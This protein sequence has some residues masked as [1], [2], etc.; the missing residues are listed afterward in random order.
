MKPSTILTLLLLLAGIAALSA[1]GAGGAPP[2]SNQGNSPP[3]PIVVS[4]SPKA[5]SIQLTTQRQFTANASS[6]TVSWSI[7]TGGSA[8][9]VIDSNG[10]YSAPSIMPGSTVLTIRATSTSDPGV[11]DDATVTLTAAPVYGA[12]PVRFDVKSRGGWQANVAPVTCGIPLLPGLHNNANTL[13][14]QA[15]PGGA[16]VPAQ[17]RVTSRWPSGHIRWVMVDFLADLSGTGGIGQ[18]QLNNGG[19]GNATGTN[20]TVNNGANDIVVN[21]GLVEFTVSKNSFNLLSSVR[22]QRDGSG[23]LDECLTTAN[24]EGLVVTEGANDYLTDTI[25]PTRV[26]VEESGPMRVTIV[27]EGVHRSALSVNKLDYTVRITAYNDLPFIG[28]TYSFKNKTGDGVAAA[29]PAAAAAQLAQY[30]VVDS[31]KLDL[32]LDFQ[33]ASPSARVGGNPI[34]YSA[35]GMTTGQYLEL[36]QYYSGAHDATDP[37]NPQP[38]GYNST[39]GD[40]SSDPLTNTWP[41]DSDTSIEYD[42]D[43]SGT[44]STDSTHAPGWVQMAGGNLS[45]TAA[46]AEFWQQYPKQLRAQAD[47]RLRVG[48]WPDAAAPLEVFAGVMKTHRMLLSFDATG[49][50]NTPAAEARYNI[51]NDPPRAVCRPEHYAAT[52]VFGRIAWTDETLTNTS[53][54]R[55]QSQAF[56]AAYMD[57]VVDHMGDILFD[58]TDGNGTATGHEYGMWNFGDSKHSSPVDGWENNAW[59]ISSAAFQWFAMSG[60]LELLNLAETTLRHFRDVD[61]L[62]ADIGTRFDYTEAGNPAVSGGKASQL[63]KTRYFANNKQHDMGNYHFGEN[64]LD[65]FNGAFLAEHWLL[66]GDATSLDV[67]KEIYIYLR[68]TWKRFFDSANG[69]QDDTMTAPTTWLSNGLMIAMAYERANGINDTS[70]NVMAQL[71]LQVV[72]T[73]QATPTTNDPSGNGFADNTGFFRAWELGHMAEALEWARNTLDDVTVDQTILNFMN[74][75]LGTNANVYL[76]NLPTPQF[77]EFSETTGGTTDYGG[78]NLMI[79]AGYIGAFRESNNAN[80]QTAADNLV[81]M[82]TPNIDDATIGDDAIRHSSFAQFFRAGPMLLA[83]LD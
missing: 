65:V 60:N 47:G 20:L 19:A 72:R 73:R 71:A 29:T 63:G 36:Y 57:E 43:N 45:V 70:A 50:L 26:E 59:G 68:G 12:F 49:S 7:P 27:A 67:L 52:R 13:R 22:I 8:Y 55:A 14:V 1:C 16:N 61:V 44:V 40:G 58:R 17:F 2:G 54:F 75:L 62:H 64:H 74:W 5:V 81:D 31:I 78:P 82:Q 79:G 25:A 39:S 38:A 32:P 83:T 56:A 35:F 53:F 76:G 34:D 69:G 77:G 42:I 33:A 48:I 23:P 24:M 15:V 28:V 21:T 10:L 46:V 11:F 18:Y 4:I 51:I 80:W 6:G 37:E 30:E 9:G 41:T 3:A 66:T